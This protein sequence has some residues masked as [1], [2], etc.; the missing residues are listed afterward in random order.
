MMV[1]V[2]ITPHPTTLPTRSPYLDANITGENA[3]NGQNVVSAGSYA[4]FVTMRL[5]ITL[6][7]DSVPEGC[8]A[9]FA[10]KNSLPGSFAVIW[11]V[12]KRWPG[13]SAMFANFGTI[14]RKSIFIIVKNVEFAGLVVEKI[15]SIVTVAMPASASSSILLTSV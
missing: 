15:S 12:A 2:L 3:R 8:Y 5:K 6:M 9:W 1:M 13:T 7:I 10:G 4:D 11:S 14:V